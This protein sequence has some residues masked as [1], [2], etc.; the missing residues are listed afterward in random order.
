MGTLWPNIP[1][2]NYFFG[3]EFEG[4]HWYEPD[5]YGGDDGSMTWM[6]WTIGYGVGLKNKEGFQINLSAQYNFFTD[7][8]YYDYGDSFELGANNYFSLNLGV[9]LTNNNNGIEND[10]TITEI[11]NTGTITGAGNSIGIDNDGT[12]TSYILIDSFI[13]LNFLIFDIS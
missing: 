9:G 5:Y 3:F 11:T 6:N 10:G 7:V 12:I 1:F 2:H 13:S 4:L 8:D